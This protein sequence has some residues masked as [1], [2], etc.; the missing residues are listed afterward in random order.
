MVKMINGFK[1]IQFIDR[2]H[3]IQDVFSLADEGAKVGL[4]IGFY[5]LASIVLG[6]LVQVY[7][8]DM[9][10]TVGNKLMWTG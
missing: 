1:A 9:V 5:E 10:L 4:D 7:G 2:H 8:N 3:G 6:K